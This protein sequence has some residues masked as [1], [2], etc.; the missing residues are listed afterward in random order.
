MKELV[1]DHDAGGK[2]SAA[3]APLI[4]L[5]LGLGVAWL[6]SGG[7]VI[8]THLQAPDTGPLTWDV[9]SGWFKVGTG[10]LW[11]LA[12]SYIG[13]KGVGRIPKRGPGE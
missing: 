3:R 13:G 9:L 1:Q 2:L 8:W 11:P 4:A 6:A 7:L 5:C 10:S 12:V